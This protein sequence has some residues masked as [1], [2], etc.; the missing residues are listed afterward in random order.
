MSPWK[1]LELV[2]GAVQPPELEKVVAAGSL[3]L[4]PGAWGSE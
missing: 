1:R 2:L 4:L 3:L